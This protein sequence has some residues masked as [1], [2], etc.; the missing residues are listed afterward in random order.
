MSLCR[1]WTSAEAV[2]V[3]RGARDQSPALALCLVPAVGAKWARSP[4][5]P[6]PS[7]T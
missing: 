6:S 1:G 5:P 7:V 3:G 4:L 2:G